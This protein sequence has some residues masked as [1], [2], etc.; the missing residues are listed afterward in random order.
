M[1]L[2][3]WMGEWMPVITGLRSNGGGSGPKA[4]RAATATAT[5]CAWMAGAP[6]SL[7]ASCCHRRLPG[8][9]DP[10]LRAP[11]GRTQF[12]RRAQPRHRLLAVRH[13]CH[14]A[15]WGCLPVSTGRTTSLTARSRLWARLALA[16]MAMRAVE[17]TARAV[18]LGP[19]TA[20]ATARRTSSRWLS[21]HGATLRR[22]RTRTLAESRFRCEWRWCECGRPTG[23]RLHAIG[24]AGGGGGGE[25]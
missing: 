12:H 18:V 25:P 2:P 4:A 1:W 15:L 13:R 8:G 17:P 22:P 3:A 7:L 5:G 11:L 9:L 10:T 21:C 20:A 19:Q 6:R 14:V 16:T 23:R 24:G